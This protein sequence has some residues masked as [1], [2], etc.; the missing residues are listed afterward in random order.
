VILVVSG[1]VLF[2]VLPTPWNVVALFGCTI[3]GLGDTFVLWLVL[4]RW[5]IRVGPE[6]MIGERARV[7]EPCRPLG[8]VALLGELWQARCEQGADPG[9]TVLVVA[10]DQL[11]L[12]VEPEPDPAAATEETATSAA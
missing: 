2:F 5:R 11:L 9:D 8:K 10:R 1:I 12:I 4:R 7:V 6:V 3:V